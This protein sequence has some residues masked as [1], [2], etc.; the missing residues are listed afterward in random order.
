MEILKDSI[1]DRYAL[2]LGDNINKN[3]NI[4]TKQELASK[5]YQSFSDET[6]AK[7]GDSKKLTEI[8]QLFLDS[9]TGNMKNLMSLLETDLKYD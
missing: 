6:K 1:Y 9:A 4:L 7:V 3:L 2:W 8:S 5:I